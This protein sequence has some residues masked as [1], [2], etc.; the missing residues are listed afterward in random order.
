M[1]HTQVALALEGQ[2]RA[3]RPPMCETQRRLVIDLRLS[4]RLQVNQQFLTASLTDIAK[5]IPQHP[6]N[7]QVVAFLV[8][9]F[10]MARKPRHRGETRSGKRRCG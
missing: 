9:E 6:V 5:L 7:A 2:L 3:S 4:G 1:Q 8:V 10:A